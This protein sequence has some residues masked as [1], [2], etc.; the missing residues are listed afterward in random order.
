MLEI[1]D[2]QGL[3]ELKVDAERKIVYENHF[4]GQFTSDALARMDKDYKEKVIPAFKGSKWAKLCDMRDYQIANNVDEMNA[5]VQYCIE[6]GFSHAALIVESAIVKMQMNRTGRNT[7][8]PPN[9]FT[10]EK[11]ADAWLKSV[12]Y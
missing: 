9:A 12:G 10:D 2:T 1:K 11:E 7:P 6:H 3:Y 4:K 8:V 5:H